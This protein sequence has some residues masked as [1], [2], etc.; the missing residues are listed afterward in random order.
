[1]SDED[2][3]VLLSERDQQ[4]LIEA[5]LNPKEPSEQLLRVFARN[6]P[7]IVQANQETRINIEDSGAR[8]ET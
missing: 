4:F 3:V 7:E 2:E 6:R 5:I 1:M 8:R